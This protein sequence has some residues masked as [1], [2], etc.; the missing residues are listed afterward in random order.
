MFY[1]AFAQTAPG[2]HVTARVTIPKHTKRQAVI[3]T[4]SGSSRYI[5]GGGV[6]AGI[7]LTIEA[8]NTNANIS[9]DSFEGE[10]SLM[11]YRANCAHTFVV[12]PDFEAWVTAAVAPLGAGGAQNQDSEVFLSV[13]AIPAD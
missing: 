13:V 3:V 8:S 10:S 5:G 12:D 11:V 6:N 4:A 9:D 1:T 7:T 2:N